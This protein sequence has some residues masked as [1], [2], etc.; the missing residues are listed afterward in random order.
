MKRALHYSLLILVAA[1]T[2]TTSAAAENTSTRCFNGYGYALDGG[3]LRYIEHHTQHLVNGKPVKWRV[4]YYD[5]QGHVIATKHMDFTDSD[6]VPVY[7]FRIPSEGYVEG[8]THTG[9]WTM[10]R[11]QG[12]DA[13]RE[14][15]TFDITPPMAA[16][17]GFDRLVKK[18]FGKL[19]AGKTVQFKFAVAGNL[20]AYDM[21][22][23]KVDTTTFEGKKAVVFRVELD[24][25]FL[26]FFAKP[27]L[28]TYDPKTQRLL[29]YRGI[30]NMHNAQGEV[31]PVRV[32]YY[33]ETPPAA[34]GSDVP[35]GCTKNSSRVRS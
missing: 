25:F 1:L 18:Q 9:G 34:K 2:L 33:S 5:P 8:I 32:S 12:A 15:Q 7:T 28:L 20:S 19:M 29:E 27:L 17:S 22:A 24:S 3:K 16:D 4:V 14:T 30:G 11:R 10:F 31:Y 6:T 21:K 13:Q 35:S 23:K 26:H